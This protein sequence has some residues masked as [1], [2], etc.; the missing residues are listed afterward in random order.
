[1]N[2]SIQASVVRP[3]IEPS[4]FTATL[5]QV[6][7]SAAKGGTGT[8]SPQLKASSSKR[9]NMLSSLK[10][11]VISGA[12][13]G[14]SGTSSA[15]ATVTANAGA[16]P[17]PPPPGGSP[18]AGGVG[19]DDGR[20]YAARWRTARM[21]DFELVRGG[22]VTADGIP[23][24]TSTGTGTGTHTNTN[25]STSTTLSEATAAS[26][27][28]S[29]SS[30][31]GNALY[32]VQRRRERRA[33]ATTSVAAAVPRSSDAQSQ[34][35]SRVG[36]GGGDG[37]NSAPR[38]SQASQHQHQHSSKG[39]HHHSRDRRTVLGDV[40]R[41]QRAA[42]MGV[43]GKVGWLPEWWWDLVPPISVAEEE[44]AVGSAASSASPGAGDFADEIR[45]SFDFALQEEEDVAFD[46]GDDEVGAGVQGGGSASFV[47]AA[48]LFGPA[49]GSQ[50][51]GAG[52]A[53]A[54]LN[55]RRSEHS[56]I[57]QRCSDTQQQQQQP[58]RQSTVLQE[59]ERQQGAVQDMCL[60]ES[61]KFWRS[62][63]GYGSEWMPSN[64]VRAIFINFFCSI[65]MYQVI[66]WGIVIYFCSILFDC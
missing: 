1:M 61:S 63:Y 56:N 50:G 16:P 58:G 25:A 12:R 5:Q 15:S 9:F 14:S 64:L 40:V 39:R 38:K 42:Q 34:T 7:A 22:G 6:Q 19:E 35:P 30:K 55:S 17:P 20:G 13:R 29:S 21:V 10:S 28:S 26:T 31:G 60:P 33:A 62:L 49:A 41:K 8:G 59:M 3:D 52:G 47:A 44:L 36:G 2:V 54:S 57:D 66:L 46:D 65:L 53:G 23:T 51:S 45:N 24:W 11:M 37:G 18:P 4:S 27:S 32:R 48:D 43:V